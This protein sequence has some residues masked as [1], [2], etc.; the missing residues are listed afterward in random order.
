MCLW[1]GLC[2]DEWSTLKK[3]ICAIQLLVMAPD[4]TSLACTFKEKCDKCDKNLWWDFSCFEAFQR[5]FSIQKLYSLSF[6]KQEPLKR[7][8]GCILF[9]YDRLECHQLLRNAGYGLEPVTTNN[10]GLVWEH[11]TLLSVIVVALTGI[12]WRVLLSKSR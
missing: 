1:E 6:L 3:R 8:E 5:K 2:P 7:F 11:T 9:I 12:S 10:M 4:L